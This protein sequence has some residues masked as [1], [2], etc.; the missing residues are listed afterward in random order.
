MKMSEVSL[1]EAFGLYKT[2]PTP[3]GRSAI[4]QDG[5]L[6]LSCWYERFHKAESGVL[7]YEEDLSND[8]GG[9]AN[10]LRA[11]LT[12]ALA[13]DYDVQL[14][15]AIAPTASKSTTTSTGTTQRPKQTTFHARKDLLGRLTFYDGQRFIVE[16][17]RRSG[18]DVE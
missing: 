11:H 4:T 15:V 12:K 5:T 7:R 14:I 16:F 8:T 1:L 2:K 3:R 17:R 13:D 10:T 9:A 6:V 18:S